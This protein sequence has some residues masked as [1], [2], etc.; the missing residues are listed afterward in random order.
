MNWKPN[1]AT[2]SIA[3]NM[4]HL[5]VINKSYFPVIDAVRKGNYKTPFTA[6]LVFLVSFF[7]KTV[8]KAVMILSSPTNNGILISPWKF[9]S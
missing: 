6:K 5:I 8:L 7:G 1:A 3:Q 9:I 2:W 4:E